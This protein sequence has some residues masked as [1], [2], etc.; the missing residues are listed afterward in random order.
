M[1]GTQMA[2]EMAEQPA[3]LEELIGRLDEIRESVQAVSPEPLGGVTMVARGSSDNAA[4]YGRYLL[5][6]ATGKPVSLA[7]PS[8]HT[9]YGIRAD[10]AGQLVIAVSQSGATPEITQTLEALQGAGGRGLAITNASDSAL[11]QVAERTLELRVGEERAVPATKT[12]TGQ[13]V[14]F[15]LL[16]CALGRAPFSPSELAGVPH[17]VQEVLDDPTPV[18]EAAETL[19]ETQLIVVAR[20]YLFAAALETALKVKETCYLLADGYSTADLRHGPIAAVTEG[21]PVIALCAPGPAQV[22]VMSLVAQLRERGA[23]VLVIGADGPADVPLPAGVPESLMPIVAVVRGQQLAYEL[24]LRLGYDPD[25]P[26][27]L[28]KVTPT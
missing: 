13:L 25:H 2:R 15:A 22:D 14:A 4:I 9:L 27:G 8:L 5:E 21:L 26:E 18:A 19:G 24:A 17:W 11:S 20:G 23:G 10:Y 28:S 16:A 1:S 6:A 7:A 3:R 12:V